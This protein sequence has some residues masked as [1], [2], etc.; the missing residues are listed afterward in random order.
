MSVT[1]GLDDFEWLRIGHEIAVGSE[2]CQLRVFLL[3]RL[4]FV[5]CECCRARVLSVMRIAVD[6]K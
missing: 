5:G 1:D 3:G 4:C 2:S 6:G